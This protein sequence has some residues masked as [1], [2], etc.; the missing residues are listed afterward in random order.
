[1]VNVECFEDLPESILLRIF[2]CLNQKDKWRLRAV[3]KQWKSLLCDFA[4]WSVV[5]LSTFPCDD[6]DIMCGAL[7]QIST[8][9]IKLIAS[10]KQFVSIDVLSLI[11]GLTSRLQGF[12]FTNCRF[13]SGL[14]NTGRLQ[15]PVAGQPRV[16]DLRR[17]V[18][19]IDFMY[20]C[21]K[22]F[23]RNLELLA[24]P[25]NFN[26]ERNFVSR[27]PW[28][29]S[30]LRFL[31]L[32][33]CSWVKDSVMS[34][35]AD[36][37][38]KLEMLNLFKC[39]NLQG[40]ALGRLINQCTELNTLVLRRT[41]IRDEYF[42]KVEWQCSKIAELDLSHCYYL[43]EMSSVSVV[44]KCLHRLTYLCCAVTDHV[45]DYIAQTNDLKLKTLELRRRH[46]VSIERLAHMISNCKQLQVL[47]VSLTPFDSDMFLKM[48]PHLP[49]LKWISFAGHE[50][51]RTS[52]V[53]RLLSE[54]NKDIETIGINYYHS[55]DDQQIKSSIL[56]T[57]LACAKLKSISL[58]GNLISILV[59]FSFLGHNINN[60]KYN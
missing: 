44:T 24:L 54:Y 59:N 29:L 42:S 22:L 53:L 57:L 7:E 5:D 6:T 35:I 47:D 48:L 37:C 31:E 45:I 32:S 19:N 39:I 49:R 8:D 51:L 14:D 33:E 20:D 12:Q 27:F 4:L 10:K 23:A 16:I 25:N 60:Y 30:S 26:T 36:N 56:S 41:S 50:V 9:G 3:S 2:N 43:D 21:L 46:P 18:G 17:S 38:P 52:D 15:F 55:T 28:S 13:Q 1:M 34:D 40:S 11:L 58:Q